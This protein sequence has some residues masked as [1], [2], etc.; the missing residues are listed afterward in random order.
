MNILSVLFGLGQPAVGAPPS[1]I[2]SE[3]IP[4]AALAFAAP[5]GI[6]GCQGGKDEV[7]QA[8]DE[9]AVL[10][11]AGFDARYALTC[12][13]VKLVEQHPAWRKRAPRSVRHWLKSLERAERA[14]AA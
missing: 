12:A 7:D 4:E 5:A 8:L 1:A 14:R 9:M 6:I 3:Q 2:V 10:L 13:A 11:D